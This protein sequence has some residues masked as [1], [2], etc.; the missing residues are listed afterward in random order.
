MAFLAARGNRFG[1][2]VSMVLPGKPPVW[3]EF[4]R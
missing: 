4:E 3:P 1:D 2:E